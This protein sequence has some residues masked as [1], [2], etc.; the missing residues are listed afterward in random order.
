MEL[1][2]DLYETVG[3]F[4]AT[5]LIVFLIGWLLLI[6][7][8]VMRFDKLNEPIYSFFRSSSDIEEEDSEAEEETPSRN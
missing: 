7:K 5:F 8:V 3:A 1:I 2:K 6:L 4:K